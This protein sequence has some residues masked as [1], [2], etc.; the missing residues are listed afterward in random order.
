MGYSSVYPLHVKIAG[1]RGLPRYEHGELLMTM[2]CQHARIQGQDRAR[3]GWHA[4]RASAFDMYNWAKGVNVENDNR[5][6]FCL[7]RFTR[8]ITGTSDLT[9]CISISYS[10]K[11]PSQ[12]YLE[13]HAPCCPKICLNLLL[14]NLLLLNSLLL[15]TLL[16]NSSLVRLM[17][18]SIVVREPPPP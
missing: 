15:N 12:S 9:W 13:T 4:V 18:E 11:K 8:R 10:I 5:A 6:M 3:I 17:F 2:L 16:L 14:L 1:G 7:R